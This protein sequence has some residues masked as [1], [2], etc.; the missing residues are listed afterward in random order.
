MGGNVLDNKEDNL[1]VAEGVSNVTEHAGDAKI[2]ASP[3]AVLEGP[4]WAVA[5]KPAFFN[6]AKSSDEAGRKIIFRW[7]LDDGS[8][9][10]HQSSVTHAFREA[11][12]Y[13]VGVT[14]TNGRFSDL[15][16]RDFHVVD[17]LPPLGVKGVAGKAADWAFQGEMFPREGE[18]WPSRGNYHPLG[19]AQSAAFP[20]TPLTPS[21][22][23]SSTTWKSR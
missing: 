3:R 9:V 2:T 11:G 6:A 15:A 4:S 21:G 16:Y 12:Y 13:R 7:D 10:E 19:N 23:R 8:P 17:D 5:G 18:Y 22:G 14:V 20:A 1:V